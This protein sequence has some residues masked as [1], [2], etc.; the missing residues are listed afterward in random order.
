MKILYTYIVHVRSLQMNV[1]N[2]FS[3]LFNVLNRFIAVIVSGL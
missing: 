1:C 3:N 2:F